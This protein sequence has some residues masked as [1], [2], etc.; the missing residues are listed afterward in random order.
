MAFKVTAIWESEHLLPSETF[1]GRS[2]VIFKQFAG[3]IF[4]KQ[5]LEL[6]KRTEA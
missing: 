2:T 4:A 5:P 1:F 6:R 3:F